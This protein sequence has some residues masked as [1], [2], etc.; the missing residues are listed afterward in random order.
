M[1]RL[2]CFE[3]L[4]SRPFLLIILNKFHNHL[5]GP[6]YQDDSERQKTVIV[7]VMRAAPTT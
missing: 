1:N 2:L 7:V 6:T 3:S 4:K 5:K